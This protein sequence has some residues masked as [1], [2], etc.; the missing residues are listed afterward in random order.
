MLDNNLIELGTRHTLA[1]LKSLTP[2]PGG[3]CLIENILSQKVLDTLLD[4]CEHTTRWEHAYNPSQHI[5][6]NRRKV[7][8]ELDSI[9]EVVHT[10]LDNNTPEINR[11]FNNQ[12]KFNGVDLW[13]DLPGYTISE[14]TDNPI[15]NAS[16]QVY[17]KN[18]PELHTTFR[19]LDTTVNTNPTPNHGY[20]SDNTVGI[21]HWMDNSV[22]NEFTRY[23]LHATW[24]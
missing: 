6:L 17:I 16:M 20:I 14:H 19:Y 21:P 11:I 22:P 10:I 13:Q 15:F 9:V 23:S 18:L 12:L 1:V 7:S 24:T 5:I 4:Y 3:L 8:W 2:V